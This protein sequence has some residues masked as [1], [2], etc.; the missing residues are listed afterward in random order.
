MLAEALPGLSSLESLTLPIYWFT[1]AVVDAAAS[2][3][4][5]DGLST[6]TLDGDRDAIEL[7]EYDQL[8]SL[9]LRHDGFPVLRFLSII[10]PFHRAAKFI[11][12]GHHLDALTCFEAQS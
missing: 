10:L 1:P 9:S 4:S 12:Q 2:C 8:Y 6:A 3:A 11:S 7:F 5:L